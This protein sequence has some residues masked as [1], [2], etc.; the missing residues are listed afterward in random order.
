[1]DNTDPNLQPS[2]EASAT[3]LQERYA[4]TRFFSQ[5]RTWFK[6]RVEAMNKVQCFTISQSN[7]DKSGERKKSTKRD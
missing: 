5:L 3:F 4:L 7:P 2:S 6:D 1:M